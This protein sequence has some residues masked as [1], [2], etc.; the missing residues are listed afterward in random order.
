M[1][2][3]VL[4]GLCALLA[5]AA[6]G[7]ASA[8]EGAAWR[9]DRG[10]VK[11]LVPLRPGGAFTATSASMN[12]TLSLAGEK[13]ARLAGEITVALAAIDTGIGLRNTHLREKYLEV[14][15]GQ[16]FDHAVVSDIR[17]KDADGEA[18]QG[19]STF[20]AALLLHGVK[21]AIDGTADIR[22][23]GND[24]RV[25]AV[26]PLLMSD[27]GIEAPNYLGVG[28]ADKLLVTVEFLAVR[29]VAK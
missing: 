6:P 29:Q 19:S 27:H 4:A 23:Q 24:R 10:D 12:G 1:K 9:I 28:V 11:I 3:W 22:H 15:K 25:K 8:A 26:F 17:I 2:G 21:H 20:T 14:G 13:P 5:G 18:Y 16:G 7:A